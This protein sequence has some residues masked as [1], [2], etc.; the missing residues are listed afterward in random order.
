MG[1]PFHVPVTLIISNVNQSLVDGYK[2][3][4]TGVAI[5]RHEKQWNSTLAFS[6]CP[7]AT[8]QVLPPTR[9]G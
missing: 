5:L 6:G 9:L 1:G 7:E 8:Q 3:A 2:N 4:G